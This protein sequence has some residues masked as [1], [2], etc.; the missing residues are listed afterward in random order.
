[1]RRMYVHF[2]QAVVEAQRGLVRRCELTGGLFLGG[3]QAIDREWSSSAPSAP[4]SLAGA[5]RRTV[6][7]RPSFARV[8]WNNKW[9][10][11]NAPV[12]GIQT[13]APRHLVVLYWKTVVPWPM[14]QSQ[15]KYVK[16]RKQNFAFFKSSSILKKSSRIFK[17]MFIKINNSSILKNVH[18]F[19]KSSPDLE[20]FHLF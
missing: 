7:G 17:D 1:M 15:Y 6:V 16:K 11:K 3:N 10:G 19:K 13:T 4:V 2:W 14:F 18:G 12:S 8:S 5:Q 20:K 9:Q